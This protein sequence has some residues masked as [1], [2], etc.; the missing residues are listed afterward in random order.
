MSLGTDQSHAVG[1]SIVPQILQEKLPQKVE[2][3]VPNA[4][5]DTGATGAKSHA[6][7]DSA[8]P[9]VA[10]EAVPKKAEEVLPEKVHPT[11]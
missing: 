2:E 5:H 1:D 10:Q 4:I 9:K 11:A 6:T 3:I 7:G 8:V